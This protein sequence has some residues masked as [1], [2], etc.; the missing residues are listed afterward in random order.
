MKKQL[1]VFLA[2]VLVVIPFAV[3][4]WVVYTAGSWLGMLGGGMLES[5]GLMDEPGESWRRWGP[6]AGAA[7]ILATIYL[8]GLLTRF[9]IFRGLLGLLDRLF[10]RL[11]G[12]KTVYQSVRELM[13]LFGP[14]SKK[15]GRTVLY[16]PPDE[17]AI[18]LGLLT[19][20]DPREVQCDDGVQ[21]VAVYFP[22]AYMI[23]GPLVY[24]P[25]EHVEEVD[26]PVET[27]LKLAATAHIGIHAQALPQER[28]SQRQ[29]DSRED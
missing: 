12:I 25:R 5:V 15:M 24:V 1:H 11:P 18:K 27:A 6:Y 21:R 10:E 19:N 26:I 3:T 22:F 9:W 20:D 16:R 23:G 28:A 8:V 2:G 13:K 17:Q 29:S 14:D 4:I 7:I